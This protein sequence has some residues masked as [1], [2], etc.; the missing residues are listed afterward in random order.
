ML[1]D[2]AR[3]PRRFLCVSRLPSALSHACS[4]DGTSFFSFSCLSPSPGLCYLSFCACRPGG[5]CGRVWNEA[6]CCPDSAPASGRRCFL[7][8]RSGASLSNPELPLVTGD[9][10]VRTR[11]AS[12]GNRDWSFPFFLL[13]CVFFWAL[14]DTGLL[15]FPSGLMLFISRKIWEWSHAFPPAM[16]TCS[17]SLELRG[18][19]PLDPSPAPQIINECLMEV[20]GEEL[21]SCDSSLNSAT[22]RA[23]VG[24]C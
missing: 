21:L 24:S 9:L 6:L 23:P 15:P 5:G 18:R 11:T 12:S 1:R 14:E 17:S 2:K 4:T 10:M 3:V 22:P 20:Y 19:F 8:L 13:Q 7:C 16:S